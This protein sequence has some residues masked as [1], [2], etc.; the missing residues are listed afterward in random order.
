MKKVGLLLHLKLLLLVVL[1]VVE[2]KVHLENIQFMYSQLMEH[3]QYPQEVVLLTIFALLVA[4]AVDVEV[5]EVVQED[6]VPL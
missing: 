2:P 6:F 3:L 1:L 5:V 4:V